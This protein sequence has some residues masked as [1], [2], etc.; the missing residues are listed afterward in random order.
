[1]KRSS[2]I[3]TLLVFV[4]S[5]PAYA[6]GPLILLPGETAAVSCATCPPSPVVEVPVVV[7][8]PGNAH[9]GIHK[10]NAKAQGYA[11]CQECHAKDSLTPAKVGSSG[12]F[13]CSKFDFATSGNIGGATDAKVGIGFTHPVTGAPIVDPVSKLPI[14]TG[15][16]LGGYAPGAQPQCRDCHYPH[17]TAGY[18]EPPKY[19]I[20]EA[21]LDCHVKAGSSSLKPGIQD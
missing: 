14:V 4:F 21:C 9:G 6:A 1:M 20:T 18:K 11:K 8:M 17:K 16:G 10:N 19:M 13:L 3:L 15:K 5:T 12:V 2:L 7:P